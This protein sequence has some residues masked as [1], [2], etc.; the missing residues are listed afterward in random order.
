[1]VVPVQDVGTRDPSRPYIPTTLKGWSVTL[2]SRS[3]SNPPLIVRL[4]TG[5]WSVRVVE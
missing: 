1:M 3:P 2:L 4:E 5:L